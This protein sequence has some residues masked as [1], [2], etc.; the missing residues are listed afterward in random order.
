[1]MHFDGFALSGDTS[2][3]ESDQHSGSDDS[4]FDSTDGD[5]SN[6]SYLVDVLKGKSEGL[7]NGSDGGLDHVEGLEKGGSLEPAEPGRMINHVVSVES[8]VGDDYD[9]LLL[10]S[11]FLEVVFDFGL[12]VGVSF[13]REGRGGGVHLVDGDDDLLDSH[14][15]SK[16]SVFSGLSFLSDTGFEFSSSGGDDE[17]GNI[18]LRGSGNHILDEISVS[19]GINDGEVV[20]GG[21]E[22]PEGDIDGDTSFSFGLQLVEDPCVFERFLS[23]QLGFLLEFFDGSFVDTSTFVDQMSS[24][25]GFTGVDVTDNDDGDMKL[26]FGHFVD[27][28]DFWI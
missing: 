1:M 11:D 19:G 22:F 23:N 9:V 14:S 25:G 7:L 16:E 4:G 18:G 2:G 17:D 15:V 12:D 6:S 8:R 3:G 24:G 5:G 13:L 26:L 21:L 27:L 20:F 10:E 28:I